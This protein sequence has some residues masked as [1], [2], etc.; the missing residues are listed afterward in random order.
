MMIFCVKISSALPQMEWPSLTK[1]ENELVT[2]F[3]WEFPL[4]QSV[5]CCAHR[6]ELA[7]HGSLKE[8]KGI[9]NFPL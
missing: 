8:V 7:A 1:R 6:M 5:P 2:R 3:K 9:S 4:A